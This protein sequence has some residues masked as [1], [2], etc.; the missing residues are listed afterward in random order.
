MSRRSVYDRRYINTSVNRQVYP[1]EPVRQD[2]R[3]EM[4]DPQSH[5]DRSWWN[6]AGDEVLSWFGDE[7]AVRRRRHDEG[8][9]RGKGPKGYTRSD[10]RIRE[11]VMDRLT[12]EWHVDATE[13]EVSVVDGEVTLSGYVHERYQKRRAE[14]VVENIPGV[15]EVENRIRV[16][17]YNP[18]DNVNMMP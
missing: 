7:Y 10:E 6:R 1:Q 3:P 5:D 15:K 17:P 8:P 9:H 12:D 13:I 4:N 18:M 11:D 2:G 14:V 16:N